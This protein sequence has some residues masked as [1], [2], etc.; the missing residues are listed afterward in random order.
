MADLNQLKKPSRK[1]EPPTLPSNANNLAKPA[2]TGANVP[3]QLKVSPEI[4]RDFHSYAIG[5][6]LAANALFQE[7]WDFYKANH[8]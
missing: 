1:G 8:G 2:A 6:D 4:R 3:L 7:V 5:R